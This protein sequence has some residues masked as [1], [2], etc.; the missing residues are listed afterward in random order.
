[1]ERQIRNVVAYMGLALVGVALIWLFGTVGAIEY[2]TTTFEDNTVG[3]I[4]YMSILLLGAILT[5]V[6][7]DKE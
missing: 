7:G 3:I 2:G 6:K 4:S 5:N 1:M